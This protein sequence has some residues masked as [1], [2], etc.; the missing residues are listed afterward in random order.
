MTAPSGDICSACSKPVYAMELLNVG[1]MTFHSD[2]FRC[3]TCHR[4]LETNFERSEL[5]FLCTT[6]FEQIVKVT[7]GYMYGSGPARRNSAPASLLGA[8]PSRGPSKDAMDSTSVAPADV[9]RSA[10]ELPLACPRGGQAA[11][12]RTLKEAI[13]LPGRAT[14][15]RREFRK[16][17][18][19]SPETAAG[20]AACKEEESRKAGDAVSASADPAA[21]GG[22]AER[23]S[24]KAA[25]T[26]TAGSK[27]GWAEDHEAPAA[28]CGTTPDV[29]RW[30]KSSRRHPRS[31]ACLDLL[32]CVQWLLSGASAPRAAA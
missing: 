17:A 28:V 13:A 26:P 25:V 5:G 8:T 21:A 31:P 1:G 32:S 12:H 22:E 15:T 30:R 27:N 9:A 7:G 16:V 6:H 14:W 23:T 3:S 2:C 11:L 24:A 18:G 29:V 4:K 19:A 10:A 20:T